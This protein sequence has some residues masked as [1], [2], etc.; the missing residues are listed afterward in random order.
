[1]VKYAIEK[2]GGDPKR[3]FTVGTSSGAMM[4]NVL[5]GA[6]PDVFAA[7]SVYS[8][9]PDGCFFVQGATATQD[10]PGWNNACANGQNIKTAQQWGD[11]VRG[12]YP[13]YTGTRPRMQI[14]HGTADNTLRYQNCAYFA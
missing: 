1:M 2:H 3:V 9:V 11:M 7:G 6:Y 14:F 12:Y 8:G 5:V 10:P 4:T 13:G